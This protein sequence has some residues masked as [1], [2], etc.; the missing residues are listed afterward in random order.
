MLKFQV[1]N[2]VQPDEDKPDA[3]VDGPEPMYLNVCDF[4]M[5]K[6]PPGEERDAFAAQLKELEAAVQQKTRARADGY[7]LHIPAAVGRPPASVH[8][9]EEVRQTIESFR[10]RLWQLIFF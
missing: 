1:R 7:I 2:L 4:L 9:V 5:K 8:G 10:G 3:W 6:Y